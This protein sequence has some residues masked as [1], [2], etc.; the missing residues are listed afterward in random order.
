MQ[1]DMP[2]DDLRPTGTDQLERQLEQRTFELN[3][4]VKELRCLY[5]ITR[6]LYGQ[7]A[8]LPRVLQ[9]VVDAL[10]EGWQY[11]EIACARLVVGDVVYETENYEPTPWQ[12]TAP[13][14]M[15]D[16]LV[17]M[18]RVCY[19]EECP[20][21]DE[22]PFLAEERSLIDAVANHV[23]AAIQSRR[24]QAA[25]RESEARHR[26]LAENAPDAIFVFRPLPSPRFEYVSPAAEQITGYPPQVFYDN[27]YLLAEIAQP[28]SRD[29]IIS[30][31]G[32]RWTDNDLVVQLRHRNGSLVWIGVRIVGIHDGDGNI[33]GIEGAARDITEVHRIGEALRESETRYRRLVETIHEGIWVIDPDQRTTFVNE[34]MA[35]MLGYTPDEMLGR[36]LVD[37]MG[38]EWRHRVPPDLSAR[39]DLLDRQF[40]VKLTHRDGNA[41]WV[42]ASIAPIVEDG[43]YVGTLATVNDITTRKQVEQNEREQRVFAETLRDT[44]AALNS[45][46]DLDELFD[47][48][49]TNL[50]RVV[51]NNMSNIMLVEGDQAHVVGLRGYEKKM[52]SRF[53]TE[54]I[55]IATTPG[56]RRMVE[57]K[58]P[59][60]IEDTIGSDAWV[61]LPETQWIR[62][63]IGAPIVIENEVIGFLN[64]DND[65]PGRFTSEDAQRMHAF[66]H[67]AAI[68]IRNARLHSQ[69]AEHN[70]MLRQAVEMAT[71]EMSQTI[72]QLEAIL[73]SS[74]SAVIMVREGMAISSVN[75]AFTRLFACEEDG[76]YGRSLYD[77]FE[78]QARA[79]LQAAVRRIVGGEETAQLEMIA[80]RRDGTSFDAS[81]ALGV[82]QQGD[83]LIGIVVNVWDVSAFKEI[84]RMK[85]SIIA[86][87]AHELRTPLTSVQGYSEIL[88]TRKLSEEA[89]RRYLTL[90]NQQAVRLAR[91]ISS[92]LDI[93]LLEAGKGVQF[94]PAPLDPG[95][96]VDAALLSF[97]AV[98]PY[99]NI[100]VEKC[101]APARVR[102]DP[103]RL[104][105][106]ITNLL[107]N[108]IKYTPEG[109][110][111]L[112]RTEA[113]EKGVTISVKDEGIGM[114]AEQKNRVFERFYRADMSNT[115]VEGAGLGLTISLLIVESHGGRIDIQSAP[116]DGSTFTVILPPADPVE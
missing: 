59:L 69:L 65:T 95:D 18:L 14:N 55:D 21:A 41:V 76:I 22:G 64:A 60:F 83:E 32:G 111:V 16:G 26:R 54:G 7:S 86:T 42:L 5:R 75:P 9:A 28:D 33:A 99:H 106:V 10:P 45:T 98:S 116:G 74:P 73:N 36:H 17:G 61:S 110:V 108:A 8:D 113:D 39:R 94:A 100:R 1:T 19:L 29:R 91:I 3:E 44:A 89:R 80:R 70:A 48:I 52:L 4:R 12:Q 24:T 104:T 6:L 93:S 78:G 88:L 34:K 71:D 13:F 56:L 25:L 46:L 20:L 63:Y 11:P 53:H 81:I 101:H 103:I 23:Q 66:A 72:E 107:S 30:A 49:L 47:L 58:Q 35:A 57:T 77:L 97:T 102:G 2:S 62:S 43:E 27:P 50:N 51:P 92:L 38:E 114:T 37:F 31:M 115:A 67:H 40:D 112:V 85:D 82:V 79:D 84:E 90:I 87:A 109:G 68:A 96:L 105:Q 15:P